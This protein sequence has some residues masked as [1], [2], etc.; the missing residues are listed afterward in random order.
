MKTYQLFQNNT[1]DEFNNAENIQNPED[2][3]LKMI[4]YSVEFY[5]GNCRARPGMVFRIIFACFAP[6]SSLTGTEHRNF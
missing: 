2:E 4:V 6:S 5:L 1:F 3:G